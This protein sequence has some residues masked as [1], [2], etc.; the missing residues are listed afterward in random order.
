MLVLAKWMDLPSLIHLVNVPE[1]NMQA[2]MPN[3]ETITSGRRLKRFNSQAFKR[4]IMN[5]V[6]PTKID[7]W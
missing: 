4:D 2:A 1:T 7:E 3:D 5:R 6:T